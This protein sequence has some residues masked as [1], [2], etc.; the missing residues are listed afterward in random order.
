VLKERAASLAT[1]LD[2]LRGLRFGSE[3]AQHMDQELEMHA[4]TA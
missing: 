1:T 4:V 3:P 2:G